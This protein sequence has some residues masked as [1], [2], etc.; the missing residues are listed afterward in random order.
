M[1]VGTR[2]LKCCKVDPDKSE[3]IVAVE[4]LIYLIKHSDI[5]TVQGLDDL[6][7]DAIIQIRQTEKSNSS[8]KSAGELFQRFITLA[9]LDTVGD[10]EGV[11]RVILERA[12][13]FLQK[14]F[15]LFAM[16]LLRS[17]VYLM[18]FF[19]SIKMSR[20]RKLIAKNAALLFPDNARILI[21]SKSRV[22]MDALAH[23]SRSSPVGSQIH[24]Y[25]TKSMPNDSGAQMVDELLKRGVQ[26]TLVPDTAVAY[27]MPQVDAVVMGAEAV[28]E[29]GGILNAL[30]S[31]TMAMIAHHLGVPVYIMVE[32]FK[33]LRIYP[34]DQRHIPEDLKWHPTKLKE[35]VS[36]QH[37][38]SS[39]KLT[40][41]PN[42]NDEPFE[43]MNDVWHQVESQRVSVIE[44][45][46]PIIDYTS[47]I[48]LTSL[49][50]DLGIITPSAVSDELIKLYL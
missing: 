21:N 16:A 46:I 29:S 22:V 4:V 47:P 12:D 1:D 25:V 20:C 9:V 35:I 43:E 11:K 10:F 6:I 18:F 19:L 24:C 41:K 26:S 40:E 32:S 36:A 44:K 49:V 45:E 8:V 37:K 27:L 38:S 23:V 15:K 7:N 30:G 48:Y 2:F 17:Y 3:A 14:V 33:F 42:V 28:V 50:T 31:C 34:L 39:M 5:L 13:V